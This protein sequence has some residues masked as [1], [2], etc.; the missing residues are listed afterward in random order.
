MISEEG[1]QKEDYQEGDQQGDQ[2]GGGQEGKH[3]I[4]EEVLYFSP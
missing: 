1:H 4:I 3:K 2:G